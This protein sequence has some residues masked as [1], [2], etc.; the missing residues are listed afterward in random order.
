MSQCLCITPVF[1]EKSR[2]ASSHR[3]GRRALHNMDARLGLP[4]TRLMVDEKIEIPLI[5]KTG[6]FWQIIKFVGQLKSLLKK[7]DNTHV[8]FIISDMVNLDMTMNILRI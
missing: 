4:S 8:K 5:L 6:I 7:E 1:R 2:R 3:A